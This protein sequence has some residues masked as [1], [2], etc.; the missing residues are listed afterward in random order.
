[1]PAPPAR[2]RSIRASTPSPPA[3]AHR[4]GGRRRE[5]D[6]DRRPGGRR[7]P[8]PRRLSA[9]RK[10]TSRAVSPACS[11]ASPQAYFQRYGDQSDALAAIAAKNHKNGA[12]N[13]LA[14]MQKDLGYEFCRTVSEKN[15]LVARPL[16]RTDCSLVSDG[17]AALVLADVETAL[18]LGKAVVFR[19]AEQVNDFLPISKRD[20]IA[21][22]GAGAGLAARAGRGAASDSTISPSPRCMTA[23]PSPSCMIYEAMGLTP[24]GPGRARHRG[25]LDREGRPAAG[26]SLGRAQGQGPSDRRHRRLHACAAG[27]A[28]HRHGGR[29]PGART[30]TSPPSSTWAAPRW[31]TMSASS[32]GCAE[33]RLG[34]SINMNKRK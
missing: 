29:D 7:H 1:M 32:S 16:R 31:R 21:Y 18:G 6:R 34:F 11:A 30:P 15:P 14:Q 17:A 20:I 24:P 12:V 3:R 27:D 26:Q 10:A 22:R 19:A 8:D 33:G 25:R 4:A 23:S 9:R 28:A 13:P 2:P 5:D